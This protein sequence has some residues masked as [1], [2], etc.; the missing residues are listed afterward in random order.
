MSARVCVVRFVSMF[1]YYIYLYIFVC[2]FQCL[3]FFSLF[4]FLWFSLWL[5]WIS[6]CWLI[7]I[8]NIKKCLL[9]SLLFYSVVYHCMCVWGGRGGRWG[10]GSGFVTPKSSSKCAFNLSKSSR[11]FKVMTPTSF[12][13]HSSRIFKVMTP[14]SSSNCA[15]NFW[16]SSS[17]FKWKTKTNSNQTCYIQICDALGRAV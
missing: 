9:F 6:L 13:K 14:K 3:L 2:F 11:I 8:M 16:K 17:I 4:F 5:T 1:L 7:L 10:E 15:F 12:P